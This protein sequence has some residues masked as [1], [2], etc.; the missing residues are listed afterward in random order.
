MTEQ[1]TWHET[2]EKAVLAGVIT[3]KTGMEYTSEATMEELE[4]LAKSAGAQVVGV[5]T[6]NRPAPEKSTYLGEG[7]LEELTQLCQTLEAELVIFDDELAGT[8][9]RN[10]EQAV[11][12]RVIDRSMLILD[13]FAS[14]AISREGKLQVELAQLQYRLP[15]L[16][17]SGTQLSRLGAGIGTRG[18][19][20][21]KLENDRRHIRHRIH[22][23]REEL[24]QVAARR[25]LH[26]QRRK[27]ENRETV[28]LV[29]YTNAGKSTVMNYFTHAGIL[30]ENKLFATLD[31]TARALTLPDGREVT[32]VDTVG[33]IRKLPHHLIEAFHSTL[34]EAVNADLILNVVDISDPEY[35]AQLEISQQLLSQLGCSGKPQLVVYNQCDKLG[36]VAENRGNHVYISAKT[37]RGMEE[38]LKT[39]VAFLP[40]KYQ[41]MHLLFPYEKSGLSAAVREEGKVVSEEYGEHGILVLADIDKRFSYKYE[42]YQV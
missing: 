14:R 19:G 11:G 27:K 25:Q 40:S 22:F 3:G 28:V 17:G 36:Q 10:I 38:L 4:E 2:G 9:Q 20:E 39:M 41:R 29:G 42:A 37:G 5:M 7:K 34:E 35:K 31:P 13:I 12:V 6:Q 30:A 26:R 16:L 15:R 1:N 8:Q 23:L 33:F 24:Q 21:S 32:L 18:P